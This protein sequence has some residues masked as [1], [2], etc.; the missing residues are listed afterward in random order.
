MPKANLLMLGI[1]KPAPRKT[2][3]ERWMA[4]RR[5]CFFRRYCKMVIG[6]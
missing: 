4:G 6:E 1:E 5:N 3:E 2:G